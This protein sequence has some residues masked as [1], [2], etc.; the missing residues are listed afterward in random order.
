[1]LPESSFRFVAFHYVEKLL[2]LRCAEQCGVCVW[3]GHRHIPSISPVSPYRQTAT[4]VP[5]A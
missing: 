1:M 3:R 5:D 2:L 4:E